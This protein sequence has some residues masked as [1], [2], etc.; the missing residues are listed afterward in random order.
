VNLC[1]YVLMVKQSTWS[2]QCESK[3]NKRAAS[4][5]KDEQDQRR[6]NSRRACVSLQVWCKHKYLFSL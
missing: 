2:S 1:G 6:H 3:I 4:S 5:E